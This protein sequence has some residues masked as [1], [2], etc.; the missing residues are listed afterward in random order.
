MK[1]GYMGKGDRNPNV[2]FESDPKVQQAL[3]RYQK[4]MRLKQTGIRTDFCFCFCVCV[5]FV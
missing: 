5:I 4:R 1:F 2:K 3:K